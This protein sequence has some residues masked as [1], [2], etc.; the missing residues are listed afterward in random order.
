VS[1]GGDIERAAKEAGISPNRILDFSSNINPMGLPPRAAERLAREAKDPVSWTRYPGPELAELRA[2]L[3]EYA[4]VPGEY[5]VI[6]AG[7]DSLIHAAVKALAPRRC[8]IPVPAFSEY[9]RAC[10]AAGCKRA[11][12]LEC[13]DLLILNNPH[14]PSGACVSRAEMLERIGTARELGATVLVDE[15]FVDYVPGESVTKDV[16]KMDGVIAIRSLTKFFGCPGLRVGY[17]VAAPEAARKLAAQL[18]PWP[19]TTLAANTLA[20][21]LRDADYR[22]QVRSQNRRAREKLS[23]ALTSLGCEMSPGAAN[24]LLIRL[25]SGRDAAQV[26]DS[27]LR[28]HAILVRECDSF[29]GLEKGRYIRVAI[30]LEHENQLLVDA[31]AHIFARA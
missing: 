14:N 5:I 7:A 16:A 11:A 27:L 6:G 20:E 19:V 29:D 18:P 8:V 1:H 31:L 9:E 22:D 30:R 23:A 2:A 13:G 24:F 21:G 26:R 25:P 10:E 4:A 3:S 12:V 15:A 28:K 17:A